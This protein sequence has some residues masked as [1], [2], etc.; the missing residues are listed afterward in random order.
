[1]VRN[2]QNPLKNPS[3]SFQNRAQTPSQTHLRRKMRPRHIPKSTF[4]SSW[5]LFGEFLEGP[6]GRA[7]NFGRFLKGKL[8][9]KWCPNPSQN[10]KKS[11][12]KT[13]IFSHIEFSRPESLK[14]V[15]FLRKNNDFHK[16]DVLK[17]IA[18]QYRC[19]FVFGGQSDEKT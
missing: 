2:L 4:G 19:C 10:A 17:K 12:L 14:I 9:P 8:R 1:M 7:L 5:T 3:K 13:S 16:I 6:R 18:K 11:T 15:I